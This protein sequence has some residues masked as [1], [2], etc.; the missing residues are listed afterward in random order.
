MGAPSVGKAVIPEK[1]EKKK[2]IQTL[3]VLNLNSK[4]S[5]YNLIFSE[6]ENKVSEKK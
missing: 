3:T 6:N 2:E 5:I 1:K 4:E